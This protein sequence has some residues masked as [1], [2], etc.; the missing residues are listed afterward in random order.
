MALI[1]ERLS[2]GL[3]PGDFHFT[4]QVS[5]RDVGVECMGYGRVIARVDVVERKV[6]DL[7]RENKR[8][9]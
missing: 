9:R 2:E 7:M 3:A 1:N 6:T 5:C 4:R 8:G